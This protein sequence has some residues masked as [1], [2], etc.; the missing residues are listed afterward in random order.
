MVSSAVPGSRG[1]RCRRRPRPRRSRTPS[2]RTSP[3]STRACPSR[4]GVAPAGRHAGPPSM[5]ARRRGPRPRRTVRWRGRPGLPASRRS[6]IAPPHATALS[7]SCTA[8]YPRRADGGGHSERAVDH[9]VGRPAEQDAVLVAGGLALA[10]V[11]DHARAAPPGATRS[12]AAS[13]KPAP[14]RPARRRRRA[15]AAAAQVRRPGSGAVHREVGGEVERRWRGRGRRAAAGR[16]WSR[17]RP[18]RGRRARCSG[19]GHRTPPPGCGLGRGARRAARRPVTRRTRRHDQRG[20]DRSRATATSA[21]E[22]SAG[23]RRRR[24]R[25]RT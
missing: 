23:P 19:G 9:E 24:C 3:R 15:S 11:D 10:A 5:P 25:C 14:P 18:V 2:A 7:A 4:S 1:C 8:T 12:F 22:V 20:D 6:A 13:G 17:R 16:R 21:A